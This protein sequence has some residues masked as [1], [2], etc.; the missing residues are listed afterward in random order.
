MT[1]DLIIF[2]GVG[3]GTLLLLILIV[4][5]ARGL[6]RRSRKKPSA[7]EPSRSR[8]ATTPGKP[9]SSSS[10]VEST[11]AR[12]EHLSPAGNS[13]TPT[14]VPDTPPVAKTTWE[15]RWGPLP[16]GIANGDGFITL[17]PGMH[18]ISHDSLPTKEGDNWICEFS[19]KALGS[20]TNGA[21]VTCWA[22][23]VVLDERGEVLAWWAE[24]PALVPGQPSRPGSA[25]VTAP[26]GS[27]RVC[28]GVQGC[29]PDK[30]FPAAD[31]DVEFTNVAMWRR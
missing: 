30:G 4:V 31:V 9:R 1:Q 6:S 2:G 16:G 29:Q 21:P 27:V 25:E 3:I 19:I 17:P 15:T 14:P 23:P 10:A 11:P 18:A 8:V 22:G 7:I 28:I 26:A 24:Q 5:M 13:E 20:P 12:A